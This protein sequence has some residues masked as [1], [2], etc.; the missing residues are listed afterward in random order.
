[1]LI[2]SSKRLISCL[3][4]C[5]DFLSLS[6]RCGVSSSIVCVRLSLSISRFSI[7]T[8]ARDP[9]SYRNFVR[10][11]KHSILGYYANF[12]LSSVTHFFLV[13]HLLR[14]YEQDIKSNKCFTFYLQ[15]ANDYYISTPLL[16][17]KRRKKSKEKNSPKRPK[18]NTF[19]EKGRGQRKER[20][21]Q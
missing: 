4:V 13:M 12:S 11:L 9:V 6:V 7:I 14:S 8:F 1:M 21:N 18:Q 3:G 17:E 19:G 2:N 5:D 10:C 20:A 15:M 16:T